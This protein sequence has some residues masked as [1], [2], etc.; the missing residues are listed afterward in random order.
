MME[1]PELAAVPNERRWAVKILRE[2]ERAGGRRYSMTVLAMAKRA[3]GIG[4]NVGEGA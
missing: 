1:L 4:L 3:L 2:S